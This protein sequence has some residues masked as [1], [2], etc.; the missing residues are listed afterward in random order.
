M[1]RVSIIVPVLNAKSTLKACLDSI[2]GASRFVDSEL[3]VIDHGSTDGS[4]EMVLRDFA[5][6][7]SVH[8]KKGGTIAS[9]RNYAAKLAQGDYLGFIDSDCVLAER[10]LENATR[11]FETIN[12]DA[13]GCKYDLPPAPHWIEETWYGLHRRA[14]DGYVNY[15]NAGNFII[16]K[17]AFDQV[18]GFDEQLPT[19]ED[20]DLGKR[21]RA[22]G[23]KIYESHDVA[24]VHLGN[25]KSL[26]QFF[27]KELWRGLGLSQARH[28]GGVDKV[29]LM[30]GLHAVLN[31]GSIP[32]A[33]LYP[34]G[35]GT[36][37]CLFLGSLLVVPVVA[38]VYRFV[39]LTRFYRPLRSVLLHY[40]FF[41]AKACAVGLSAYRKLIGAGSKV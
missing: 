1:P 13:T 5:A 40:L 26:A 30:T 7:C 11:V 24:A 34:G 9:L 37:A 31:I 8:Q 23:L 39:A 19:D 28:E 21:M 2:V 14:R 3:I 18:G 25:P 22:I 33:V 20:A 38:T 36:R 29:L 41:S 16:K 35:V 10:H 4:Y 6:V 17:A 32:L 27:K 12:P 15:L